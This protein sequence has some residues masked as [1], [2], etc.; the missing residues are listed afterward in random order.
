M[1]MRVTSLSEA[2]PHRALLLQPNVSA[3]CLAMIHS[4][5]QAYLEE[6][7]RIRQQAAAEQRRLEEIK[8]RKLS[9]LADM[10]VP[11]KY[12]AELEK[13]RVCAH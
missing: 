12:R 11:E 5:L 3:Y 13:H 6:G 10:G 8:A 1:D 7:R 9:E 2:M 4:C